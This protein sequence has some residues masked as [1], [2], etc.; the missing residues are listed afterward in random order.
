MEHPLL[1]FITLGG[2]VVLFALAW[3]TN[4]VTQKPLAEAN[5]AS[6]AAGAFADNHLRNAEVIE[7]MGMLPGLRQRWFSQHQ[8]DGSASG[9]V[10][11]QFT[12][13]AACATSDSDA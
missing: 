8:Q 9:R 12:G 6:I 5:Q 13:G 4:V 2:S 3:L 10:G 1:G 7:A 11:G